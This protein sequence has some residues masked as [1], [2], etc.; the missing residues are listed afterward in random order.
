MKKSYLLIPFI[1]FSFCSFSQ[2]ALP[3][4]TG[5][6]NI[7]QRN[8]WLEFRT[9]LIGTYHWGV[10]T[11]NPYSTPNC[12]YH[13]YPVGSSGSDTTVDWFVSPGFN[14]TSGGKIDSLKVKV[15]SIMGSTTPVDEIS[16]YLLSGSNNPSTATSVILLAGL[17]SLVSNQDIWRDTG[18]FVIPATSGTS[19]IA[20]KYRATNNWFVI[21]MDN[22]YFS[23]KTS[24]IDDPKVSNPKMV[25]Y[26]NPVI[27]YLNISF[28]GIQDGVVDLSF[29]NSLGQKV[30]TTQIKSNTQHTGID[31]SN[32][33]PGSYFVR[34]ISG[35]KMIYNQK[36]I[37]LK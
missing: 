16:L 29:T 4:Y 3:Y 2:T 8:G 32:L 9:G 13:D 23:A 25:L 30:L 35:T 1:I 21:N 28:S 24:G 5:F 34:A 10:T 31:V 33:S 20:I 36:L 37:I 12:L 18:N 19:Y 15:Y 22:L 6:D 27:D 17:K 14:F 7:A 11:F 26:P